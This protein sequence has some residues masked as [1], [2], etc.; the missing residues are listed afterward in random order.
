MFLGAIRLEGI[1]YESI[2][3]LEHRNQKLGTF[4]KRCNVLVGSKDYEMIQKSARMSGTDRSA[5]SFYFHI[6]YLFG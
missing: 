2:R 1:Q 6:P 4:W 5:N 3:I